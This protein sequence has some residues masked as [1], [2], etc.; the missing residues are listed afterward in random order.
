MTVP[1]FNKIWYPYGHFRLLY[2][3]AASERLSIG[4]LFGIWLAYMRGNLHTLV[5]PK[6]H[7]ETLPTQMYRKQLLNV[8]FPS[9]S[10]QWAY[11]KR[12]ASGISWTRNR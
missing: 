2:P 8:L 6:V 3:S 5:L 7:F 11:I 1:Y 10:R 12:I 4:M 9:G